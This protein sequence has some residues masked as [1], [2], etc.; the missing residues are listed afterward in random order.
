MS[1]API[2]IRYMLDGEEPLGSLYDDD[3][4]VLYL[5]RGDSP[6]EAI[7][8]DSR[9]GVVVRIAP[10]TGELVGFTLLDWA[11]RWK[12]CATIEITLPPF[13]ET[14]LDATTRTHRVLVG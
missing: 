6:T 7:G 4:D 13:G 9:E 1:D 11:S 12:D 2:E 10:D 3:A 14:E 5:W 8:L